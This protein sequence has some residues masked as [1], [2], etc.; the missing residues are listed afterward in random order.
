MPSSF[1]IGPVI[2]EKKIFEFQQYIFAFSQ[3]SHLEKGWGTSFK[4]IWIPFTQ[5]CYVPSLVEIGP[6]V[7][8]KKT[9]MWKV[10][11]N[12]DNTTTTD[13]GQFWS[14]M[15]IWAF[16]LGELKIKLRVL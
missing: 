7:L 10:Y 3:L 11:D 16:G 2:L 6:V 12:N 9:K 8:E 1:E 14:E 13:N 15:L 5:G 4:Q